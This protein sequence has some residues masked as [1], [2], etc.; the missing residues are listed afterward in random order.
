ML[1]DVGSGRVEQV[2]ARDSGLDDPW[3]ACGQGDVD[4][5][6]RVLEVLAEEC[7]DGDGLSC[8]VIYEVSEADSELEWFGATC[9]YRF[10]TDLYADSC[11]GRI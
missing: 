9:G 4:A 5:C 8:D 7:S 3:V 6:A 11:E 10:D 1:I 2:R